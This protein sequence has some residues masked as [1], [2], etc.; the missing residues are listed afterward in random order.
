MKQLERW[1]DV[2]VVFAGSIP[3]KEFV[4]KVSRNTNLSEVLEILE[5][6]KIHFKIEGDKLT[7]MP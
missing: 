4:G 1:Y 3:Q 2:Q 5:L 6:S 7:V